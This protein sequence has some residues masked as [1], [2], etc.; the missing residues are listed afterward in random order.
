MKEIEPEVN[1]RSQ[2]PGDRRVAFVPQLSVA[3]LA[4][5]VP[6]NSVETPAVAAAAKAMEVRRTAF[7]IGAFTMSGC[8]A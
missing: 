3:A 6:M 4:G 2:T 1:V 7:F 5:T 8:G